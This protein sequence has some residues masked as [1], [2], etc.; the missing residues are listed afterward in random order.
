MM[1][2]TKKFKTAYEKAL[3][4]KIFKRGAA[5]ESQDWLYRK[6]NDLGV[7][8]DSKL[9][10]WIEFMIEPANAP[11]P[12]IRVRVW[13]AT[14]VALDTAVKMV[15]GAFG[16]GFE[17]VNHSMPY[18]CRPPQQL[19]SRVYLEFKRIQAMTQDELWKENDPVAVVIEDCPY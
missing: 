13:G 8:W 1:K 17:C 11:T 3:Q 9:G 6:L 4:L 7:F 14:G 2:Q 16:N 18:V 12:L 15:K 10:E 5:I 19:E